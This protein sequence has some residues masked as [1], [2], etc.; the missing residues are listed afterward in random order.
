MNRYAIGVDIG[1]T[2][3]PASIVNS[4]GE[5]IYT[6]KKKT[7]AETG[8]D[9]IINRICNSINEL[10]K[11]L[12]EN[13]REGT[14]VGVGIG[15][16]GTLDP[17]KGVVVNCPN[18]PN[19][20]HVPIVK[21]I[22]DN[23]NLPISIDND[24]N[25]AALAEHWIGAGK[26]YKNVVLITLGTGVGGGIIIND[27]IYHGS[28]GSAG[29]LGHISIAMDGRKCACGNIGCLEAYASATA[30]V[31]RARERLQ[32]DEITSSL[33]DKDLSSLTTYDIFMHAEKGDKFCQDI[34]YE[35]GTYLGVG[36]AIICNIFDPDVIV[37]G[38]GFSQATKYLIP[39]A[40]QE[41][42]RRAFSSIIDNVVI[43]KT[44]FVNRSGH[45]GAAKL[46]FD[47]IASK[48]SFL[49]SLLKLHQ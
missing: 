31:S 40:I 43:T 15:V 30:T 3:I 11:Y 41:A 29:E 6:I 20:E 5:I 38:G 48:G 42:K 19:W 24:A 46:A 9:R 1:G 23:V 14:L 47:A 26:G 12:D 2:N 37:I 25:C 39:V 44:K 7:H 36:I 10:G 28:H 35:T 32:Y 13:F 18:L 33:V 45:I 22:S 4:K 34:L 17:E 21:L 49:S 27:R 8:P 16:P